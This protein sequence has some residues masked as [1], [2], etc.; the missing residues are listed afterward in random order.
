[1]TASRM[2]AALAPVIQPVRD[3]GGRSRMVP[4]K[5]TMR[6]AAEVARS[7]GINRKTFLSRIDRN[8]AQG[9]GEAD[10]VEQAILQVG[11]RYGT[12]DAVAARRQALYD[13]VDEQRPMTVRAVYYQAVVRGIIEKNERD[14]AMVKDDLARLRKG[15]V[16][17]LLMPYDWLVDNT[18]NMIS[19][20]GYD[21]VSEALQ[22][23]ADNY[24]VNLWKDA[25]C[26]VIIFLEKDGLAGV[27]EQTTRNC[28]VDLVPVR[29]YASL[30]LLHSV[31]EK[32]RDE[33][34]PV[35]C[36]LLGDYDPSGMDAHRA[37]GVTLNDMAANVDF[38]FK[39]L[40]LTPKQIKDWKLPGERATKT[41]DSR[42]KNWA[43]GDDMS[44]ELDAVEPKKLRKLVKDAIDKHMDDDDRARIR[45]DEADERAYIMT[46][47]EQVESDD[48]RLE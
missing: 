38:H 1:M 31:A 45:T 35:F 22:E 28:G 48:D 16:E 14:Y 34:R 13:I 36:Y 32:Y 5:G 7:V 26:R 41:T 47:S 19:P 27:I 2:Q 3:R 24:R 29:G 17:G 9:M 11:K 20:F 15:N 42:T 30:S 39:R 12:H 43:G 8:I 6:R 44:V 40:G 21:S 10:A 33:L 4:Y 37:L 25:D 18:R 46:L 23:T